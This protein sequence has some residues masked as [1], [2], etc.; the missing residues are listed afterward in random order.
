MYSSSITK[1]EDNEDQKLLPLETENKNSILD[2]PPKEHIPAVQPLIWRNIIGIA[3][4]HILALY[5]FITR[6]YKIKFWTWIFGTYLYII[7]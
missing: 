4:L 5:L 2:Q 7:L 6:F 1:Y 3:V